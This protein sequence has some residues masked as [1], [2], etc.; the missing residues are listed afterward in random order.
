MIPYRSALVV[1]LLLS[2]VF[3]VRGED[4]PAKRPMTVEDLWKLERIGPPSIAP[5][6]NWCVVEVTAYDL[7]KDEGRSNLWLLAT[8]GS[9]QKQLTHS[10]GKNSGPKC[11]PPCNPCIR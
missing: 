1:V 7:D 8:D 4:A 10:L 9:R 5:D 2:P 11:S 3:K 6:G